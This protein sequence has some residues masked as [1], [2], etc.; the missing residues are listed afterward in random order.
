MDLSKD[1][2][3][4]VIEDAHTTASRP[5]IDAQTVIRHYN[6]LWGDMTPTKYKLA[7]KKAKD[8]LDFNK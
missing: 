8:L 1:Y 6:W 5:H 4:T 7:V 2:K 3:V